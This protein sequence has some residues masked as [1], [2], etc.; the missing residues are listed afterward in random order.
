MGIPLST[1]HRFSRVS[2]VLAV[3]AG[4]FLALQIGAAP[5][6]ISSL[7]STNRIV[8]ADYFVFNSTSPSLKTKTVL[9]AHAMSNVNIV[10]ISN[11][12]QTL[13]VTQLFNGSGAAIGGA[14]GTDG[15]IQTARGGTNWGETNFVQDVNGDGI[16]VWNRPFG[17]LGTSVLSVQTGG[18]INWGGYRH[19]NG[20]GAGKL[21]I[22][23]AS[24]NASWGVDIPDLNV[25]NLTVVN[26]FTFK[27]NA[28]VDLTNYWNND[29]IV[30]KGTFP[31]TSPKVALR[32]GGV[33]GTQWDNT[34]VGRHTFGFGTNVTAIALGSVVFGEENSIA[35]NAN[36]STIGG[37]VQ[38]SIAS[39]LVTSVIGG[40]GL[41]RITGLGAFRSVISG[42]TNNLISIPNASDIGGAFI[43]GGGDHQALSNYVAIAGG[44][45]NIV[46]SDHSFAG[47]GLNNTIASL[48]RAAAIV[49]GEENNVNAGAGAFIGAGKQNKIG[50]NSSQQGTYGVIGGGANNLIANTGTT[51][52]NGVI[53]GG[54]GNQIISDS[55]LTVI[56]GGRA[57][58]IDMSTNAV[59]AGGNG[60]IVT[61][62]HLG[63]ILGGTVNLISGV[64]R[65]WI[66]G[67]S[68]SVTAVNAGVIGNK[69]TNALA[70]SIVIAP[71][72]DFNKSTFTSSNVTFF[73]AL[74]TAPQAAVSLTADNQIVTTSTNSYISLSSDNGTA[75][76]RT[77]VLT[78]TAQ[79]AGQHLTLEWTGTN[80]GE[81]VDD[82]A[83]NGAGNHRLNG[84]WT[85]TQYD[86][87]NL[88]FN[89]TDWIEDSRSPN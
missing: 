65:G 9:W 69:G 58:Q 66:V 13:Y 73:A 55:H 28:V 68:N 61:S 71:D 8:S 33:T 86:T 11:R 7:P 56:G 22:S 47:A 53:G 45:A 43:G 52:T 60:N 25:T 80:A 5:L 41:N 54:A 51:S 72:G 31:G 87:L 75:G 81:L 70:N 20:A 36:W 4:T 85:P 46:R 12:I 1:I 62:A 16:S 38:N 32:F 19:T 15:I 79:K 78:G 30:L 44:F 37:G 57:N 74:V 42:G 6:P 23:D 89:G 40:G 2:P 88:H 63:Q 3:I 14:F 64:A 67:N 27:G 21:F 18:I 26:S 49:G 83:C 35:T 29:G 84:T 76:N 24:G 50:L 39:N 48:S 77:F 17:L 34:N 59:I 82:S 10:G